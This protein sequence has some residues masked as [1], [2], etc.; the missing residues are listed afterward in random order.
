MLQIRVTARDDLGHEAAT[1]FNITVGDSP[2][3]AIQPPAPRQDA[4]TP[5]DER[6]DAGAEDNDGSEVADGRHTPRQ[7]EDGQGAE[8]QPVK[9]G[10]ARFADQIRAARELAPAKEQALLARA[11]E[12][13]GKRPPGGRGAT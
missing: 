1:Q 4:S 7:S 13:K 3:A 12:A 11:L 2:G 9:R 6:A 5:A 8:K 10:A